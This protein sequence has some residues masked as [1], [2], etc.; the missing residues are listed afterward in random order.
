MEIY[1]WPEAVAKKLGVSDKHLQARR[2][3]GDAPELFA[4]TERCLVTTDAALFKWLEAKSVPAGYKCR[5]A[6]RVARR[7]A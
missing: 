2:A 6:T 3:L 7:G 1:A 5:P 4:V